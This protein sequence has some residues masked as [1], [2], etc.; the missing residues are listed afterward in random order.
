MKVLRGALEIVGVQD[1]VGT[2]SF[3]E[4]VLRQTTRLVPC[5]HNRERCNGGHSSVEPQQ[6]DRSRKPGRVAG[7][8]QDRPANDDAR[9]LHF[10]RHYDHAQLGHSSCRLRECEPALQRTGGGGPRHRY[11]HVDRPLLAA[12][13]LEFL[14]GARL[15]GPRF[16]CGERDQYLV[17]LGAHDARHY[18][19]VAKSQ[20]VVSKGVKVAAGATTMLSSLLSAPLTR[21]AGTYLVTSSRP[22][23]IVTLTLPSHP[24]GL[25]LVAPL[26]G[27]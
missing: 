1:S 7:Q 18:D 13:S 24:R 5:G 10:G 12:D 2:L 17:A 8:L 11:G 25:Y 4:G 20:V 21:P 9:A 22:R 16:R 15:H 14:R 3:D 27:R 6:H 23:A 26:D 19:Y